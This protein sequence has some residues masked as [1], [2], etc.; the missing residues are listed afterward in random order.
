[1]P[2]FWFALVVLLRISLTLCSIPQNGQARTLS[3]LL[4]D[5]NQATFDG[6]SFFGFFLFTGN[7]EY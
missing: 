5:G 1:M 6:W 4:D 7:G 3:Y 2:V